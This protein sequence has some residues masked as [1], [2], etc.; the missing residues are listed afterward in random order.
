MDWNFIN[1]FWIN[2]N[3]KKQIKNKQRVF[4]IITKIFLPIIL[5]IIA[6]L[7]GAFGSLYLKF[8]SKK[9]IS[10]K[11]IF[12]NYEI[13]IGFLLYGGSTIPFIIALKF[14]EL[15]FVYPLTALSYVWVILLSRKYLNESITKNKIL[16]IILI[17][18]GIIFISLS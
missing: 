15:S 1:N 5:V 8:G 10:I 6:T 13:I 17:M 3:N 16:G 7:M 11:N 9:S 4:K 14:G 18:L 2:N 12:K